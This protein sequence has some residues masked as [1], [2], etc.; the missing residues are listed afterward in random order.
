MQGFLST[1]ATGNIPV[2]VSRSL[3]ISLSEA[4]SLDAVR[5]QVIDEFGEP[6]LI[7]RELSFDRAIWI[8]DVDGSKIPSGAIDAM[9]A[10]CGGPAQFQIVDPE[11]VVTGCSVTYE[12]ALRQM[13]SHTLIKFT[14]I[15][16]GLRDI[17]CGP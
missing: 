2:S 7:D 12:V 9:P 8:H 13:P 1:D 14:I 16:Y 3:A 15:D 6:T 17:D 10:N 4:P 11:S 5:K